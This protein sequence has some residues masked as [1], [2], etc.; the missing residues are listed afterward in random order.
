[1]R[2]IFFLSYIRGREIKMKALKLYER[3]FLTQE[4]VEL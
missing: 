2:K 4:K 1:M 3:K